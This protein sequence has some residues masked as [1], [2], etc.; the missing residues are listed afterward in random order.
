LA[1]AGKHIKRYA[2]ERGREITR[3]RLSSTALHRITGREQLRESV[4]YDVIEQL[5]LHGWTAFPIRDGGLALIESAAVEGWTKLSARR[6]SSELR[7]AAKGRSFDIGKL[8]AEL[9]IDDVVDLTDEPIDE[10]E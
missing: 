10:E 1:V 4:L 6:V 5:G 2:E 7:A 8:E 9:G 3:L